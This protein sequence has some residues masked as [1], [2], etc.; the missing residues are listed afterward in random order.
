[1]FS[2]DKIVHVDIVFRQG[3]DKG[4]L[5]K[6]RKNILHSEVISTSVNACSISYL[7]ILNSF[8]GGNFG[9]GLIVDVC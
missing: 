4:L 6:F 1:M 5:L 3:D 8:A 9:E 2:H 7:K